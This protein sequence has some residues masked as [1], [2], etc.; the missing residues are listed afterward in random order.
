MCKT[1]VNSFFFQNIRYLRKI[2]HL[3][4]KEMAQILGVSAGTVGRMEREMPGVRVNGQMLCRLCDHFRLSADAVLRTRLE[5][6][7]IGSGF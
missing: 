7:G 1:G 5:D 4:R 2:F 3:S 6:S